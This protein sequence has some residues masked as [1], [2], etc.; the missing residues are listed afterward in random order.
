[1]LCNFGLLWDNVFTIFAN[2]RNLNQRSKVRKP[3]P[4]LNRLDEKSRLQLVQN[5][6][7]SQKKS[8]RHLKYTNLPVHNRTCA[9]FH[10]TVHCP[11]AVIG[12]LFLKTYRVCTTTYDVV[13]RIFCDQISRK[14]SFA[15]RTKPRDSNVWS[16]NGRS[17]TRE[18]EQGKEYNLGKI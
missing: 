14:K 7:V 6:Y 10:W 11:R 2:F 5:L 15:Y 1:M 8:C 12:K 16:Q 3:I 4:Y 9:I 17:E 13:Q 18:P